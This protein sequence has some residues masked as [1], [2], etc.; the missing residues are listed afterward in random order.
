MVF[1]GHFRHLCNDS[2]NRSIQNAISITKTSSKHQKK[3]K[4]LKVRFDT[5]IKTYL[6]KYK[7][8]LAKNRSNFPQ[9]F[10]VIKLSLT[11]LIKLFTFFMNVPEDW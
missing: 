7:I 8:F 6:E 11:K 9:F 10:Q 4:S 2:K 1:E 3:Q 5:S